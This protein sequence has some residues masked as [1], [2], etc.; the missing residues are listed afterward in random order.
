MWTNL[1]FV[2]ITYIP[3]HSDAKYWLP[4]S[5]KGQDSPQSRAILSYYSVTPPQPF[6]IIRNFP[7][8]VIPNEVSLETIYTKM[9][10]DVGGNSV[11][12]R[13]PMKDLIVWKRVDGRRLRGEE[14]ELVMASSPDANKGSR[15]V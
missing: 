15:P 12:I 7:E 10:A 8:K 3:R 5:I 9:V 14:V 6:C 2:T 11:H 1:A 4:E 13:I